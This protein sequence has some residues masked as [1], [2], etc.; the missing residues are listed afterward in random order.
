MNH[1]GLFY[2]ASFLDSREGVGVGLDLAARDLSRSDRLRSLGSK[3]PVLG[4][5]EILVVNV[6]VDD[7]SHAVLAVVASGLRAVVPDGLLVLD[8]DLEDIGSLAFFSGKVE[9]RRETVGERLTGLAKAGLDN[10]VVAREEVPPG[11]G[12]SCFVLKRP[13]GRQAYSITSPISAKT[14]SGSKRR[15]PRPT[16]I[17]WVSPIC[18]TGVGA[19]Q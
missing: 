5:A 12:V 3:L 17:V 11:S 9:A 13:V 2:S 18:F 19:S 8:S 4:E 6:L 14:L 7:T 10:G 16:A 1:Q 15:P